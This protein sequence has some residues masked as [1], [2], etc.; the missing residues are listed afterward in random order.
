MI[1][2]VPSTVGSAIELTY[3]E[4]AGLTDADPMDGFSW[5]RRLTVL[6][7]G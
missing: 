3:R 7:N 4:L 6:E 5:Q 1:L 2:N